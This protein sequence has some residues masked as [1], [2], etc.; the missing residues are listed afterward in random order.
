VLSVNS[1]DVLTLSEI[2]LDS[3]ILSGCLPYSGPVSFVSENQFL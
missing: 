3:T 1:L 2:W